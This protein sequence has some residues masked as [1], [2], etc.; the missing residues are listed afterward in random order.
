MTLP[1]GW[2][3]NQDLAESD[4]LHYY[5]EAGS[6]DGTLLSMT[7]LKMETVYG[8]IDKEFNKHIA[9]YTKAINVTLKERTT[10]QVGN[11]TADAALCEF[12]DKGKVILKEIDLFIPLNNHQYYS[13]TMIC[14]NNDKV[15]ENLAIMMSCAKSFRLKN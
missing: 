11:M 15:D 4:T 9:E 7:V 2:H 14:E 1:A 3:T 5:L 12:D 10:V 13:I 8:R 6:D